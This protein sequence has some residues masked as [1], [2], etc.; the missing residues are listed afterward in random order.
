MEEFLSVSKVDLNISGKL[1]ARSSR[2]FAEKANALQNLIGVMNTPAFAL[3]NPHTSR[4]QLTNAIEELADLESFNLFIPNI[5]VQEDAQTQQLANQ[6][7]QST[8]EIDAVNAEE[9]ITDD[10]ELEG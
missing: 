8:Q 9:P 1:R 4:L 10:E 2:L 5:G 6:T 7:Q 3:L